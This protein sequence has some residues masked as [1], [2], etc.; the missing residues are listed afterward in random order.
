MQASKRLSP[1]SGVQAREQACRRYA[2]L[3][4][5]SSGEGLGEVKVPRVSVGRGQRIVINLQLWWPP[6]QAE[7]EGGGWHASCCGEQRVLTAS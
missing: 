7:A 1:P 3:S 5:Y 4:A 6:L 2:K